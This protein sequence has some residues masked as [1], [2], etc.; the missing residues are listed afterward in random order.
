MKNL[1]NSVR[2][3]LKN[4]S[5]KSGVDMPTLLRR[6]VQERLLYRLSIS[7]E[8]ENFTL[9]GGL[10]LAA[11]NEGILLR[12]T[13]DIDFNG[14]FANGD[15][16][17]LRAALISI[18]SA[19]APDDGV[20][21]MLNTMRIAKDRTGIVPGGKIVILAKV[22]TARVELKVDVG[23]GNP[24]TPE[25]RMIEFPTLL[26]GITAR[27]VMR[28]YPLETVIAEKLH[29]IAQFGMLNSR[30]KDFFDVLMLSRLQEFDA[31][32]LADAV[33]KTFTHQR[34]EIPEQF[35]GFSSRFVAEGARGWNAFIAKLPGAEKQDFASVV[36]DI[37]N[38]V[39]PIATSARTGE[40]TGATWSPHGGWTS[41]SPKP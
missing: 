23:F 18:L 25:T 17:S 7:S 11:Y 21:F 38:F 37:A 40:R 31:D 2:A 6:Y 20:E 26:D 13:E 36:E 15:I 1:G 3:R 33:S 5:V 12:P 8:A 41:S 22:D 16:E 30:F 29:A 32:T 34:R 10:L 28:S 9:K 24:V 27:P 39:T 19:N 14:I 4:L 35:S